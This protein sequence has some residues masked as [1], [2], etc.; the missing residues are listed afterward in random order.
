MEGCKITD[1]YIHKSSFSISNLLWSR[2]DLVTDREASQSSPNALSLR[3]EK[4]SLVKNFESASL[5]L[6]T[7]RHKAMPG[8]AKLSVSTE[9]SKKGIAESNESSKPEKP[10]FSYNALI[11]MAIRQSPGRRL[12]LNGIY[13]FIMENFPYYRQNRQGWQNS[14]RHNLSLNKCFV[15][16]PRHYDDP[17]KGNY[18]ML[19]PCSEDV[20][21]GGTSGKLRRR[22]GAGSRAKLSLKK[23]GR[24]QNTNTATVALATAGPFYW[25]VPPILQLQS[26]MRTHFG[27]GT[28]LGAHPSFSNHA[29]SV[30][31]QR[32]RLSATNAP[33]TERFVQTH[34]EMSYIGV[35][36][37]QARRHQIGSSCT[38][39]STSMPAC[40]L[41]L[42]DPC[43]FNMITGQASYFYS[44]QIP[45]GPSTAQETSALSK[46]SPGHFITK[47]FS[48][49]GGC[50]NEVPNYY[51]QVSPS[52]WNLEK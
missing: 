38:T 50:Y 9:E 4:P 39:F 37:A 2:E 36:C 15:K 11:M 13:E 10:P 27:T 45:F 20:F 24:L 35:S 52:S 33:D 41:P 16:V 28:Y 42:S 5:K 7:T 32:S 19:D 30:V 1:G 17:G 26:P 44:H 21:I 6:S 29:T 3:T 46:T 22:T 48:E 34:Q 43:S 12:T 23:G 49:L 40:P 8:S 14:I 47:R 25:P 31:S 18:W 51:P